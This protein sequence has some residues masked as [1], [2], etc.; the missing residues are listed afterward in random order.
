MRTEYTV[1]KGIV[2]NVYDVTL[3]D[4]DVLSGGMVSWIKEHTPNAVIQQYNFTYID[5]VYENVPTMFSVYFEDSSEEMLYKIRWFDS[6][7]IIN[8]NFKE[9]S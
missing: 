4:I 9:K 3:D 5:D 6:E 2:P 7:K 1:Y 8:T